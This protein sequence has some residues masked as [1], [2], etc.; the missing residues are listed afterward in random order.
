V[1]PQ[2]LFRN[3]WSR[4]TKTPFRPPPPDPTT[5]ANPD[6]RRYL[7]PEN[8]V[9]LK[10]GLRMTRAS[11]IHTKISSAANYQQTI[12]EAAGSVTIISYDRNYAFLGRSQSLLEGA[13]P[14]PK[15]SQRELEASVRLTRR[16]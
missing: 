3:C 12:S 16:S 4:N 1:E 13:L 11:T 7:R 9:P 5:E 10:R 6:S 2:P 14:L 8:S 15:A